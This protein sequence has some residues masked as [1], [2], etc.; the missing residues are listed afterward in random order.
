MKKLLLSAFGL[1]SI[2]TANA[3]F[4]TNWPAPANTTNTSSATS[5]GFVGL[6]IRTLATS[7]NLPTFNFQVHGTTDFMM[8]D[9]FGAS[10][11]AGKTSRI[12]LTN[13][14]TGLTANDGAVIRLSDNNLVIQNQESGSFSLSSNG[15]M[16]F[17][18]GG[19]GLYLLNSKSFF[20]SSSL[21][22]GLNYG[23]VNIQPTADNGLFVRTTSTGKYALGL[24]VSSDADN[25]IE[26]YGSGVTTK[27]FTVQGTG[28]TTI[29]A[30][31]ISATGNVFL[32]NGGTN[33][34]L[35]QLTNDGILR[36][37]QII[38]DQEAWADYVF[39]PNYDLLSLDQV[40]NYISIN[41]H[42]PN[43]PSAEEISKNGINLAEMDTKLM[44]KIEELT[45]YILQQEERM[46]ALEQKIEGLEKK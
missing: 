1:M 24:K 25:I 42:L 14:V 3:Q 29:S 28:S 15:A 40:K 38:V 2:A 5:A 18:G 35:L 10:Y 21:T 11:N 9:K 32:V 8:T 34:K 7:T 12:G 13:S 31:G 44:E 41:G 27:V 22:A 30:T 16:N 33:R 20:G 23:S 19:T 39:K 43:I 37:R 45:L 36:A 46:K 26:G 17:I 6:G 4:H